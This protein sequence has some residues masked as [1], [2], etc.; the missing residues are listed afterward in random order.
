MR[1]LYTFKV[2]GQTWK[3]AVYS[4]KAYAKK[5]GRDSLAIC[6]PKLREIDFHAD[7]IEMKVIRHELFHAYLYEHYP[8]EMQLSMMQY[9]E[10]CCEIFGRHGHK[11]NAQAQRLF[12]KLKPKG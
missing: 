10:M 4:H 11:M 7:H 5:N 8:V 3:A 6:T 9:E 2:L 12:A 1:A